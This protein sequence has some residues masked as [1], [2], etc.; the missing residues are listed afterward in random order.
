MF[1]PDFSE[2]KHWK[3]RLERGL[4]QGL[5]SIFLKDWTLKAI[6]FAITMVLWYG[7]TGRRTNGTERIQGVHLSF[8]LPDN[9]VT[10]HN[11]RNEVGVTLTGARQTL[12]RLNVRELSVVANISDYGPGEHTIQLNSDRV[13][14]TGLPEGVIYSRIEPNTVKV[15][16]ENTLT[17]ELP[18]HIVFGQS[19]DAG[20][21]I[22]S[23]TLSPERVRVR[24]IA[25]RINKLQRVE[26]EPVNLQ[27]QRGQINLTSLRLVQPDDQTE[28]L[29]ATVEARLVIEEQRSERTLKDIPVRAP[30]GFA[31]APNRTTVTVYGPRS[32]VEQLNAQN[33]ALVLVT[34]DQSSAPTPTLS[35]TT[36]EWAKDLELRA[37][38]PIA[39]TLTRTQ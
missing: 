6:A 30:D 19:A 32:I 22:K 5:R 15:Q 23:S 10:T 35:V 2:R 20:F 27:G 11:P 39:F 8:R 3:E 16:L 36:P 37:T 18:V 12:D 38:R 29:D 4:R 21:E 1:R 14:V 13:R 24:G 26:S 34:T 25:S 9:T 31:A 17:R 7:A 28:L 33:L